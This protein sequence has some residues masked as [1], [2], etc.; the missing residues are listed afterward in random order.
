SRAPRRRRHHRRRLLRLHPGAHPADRPG[1]SRAPRVES[2]PRRHVDWP[3][4]D[5][6]LR[7]RRR[8]ILERFVEFLRVDTVS[9]QPERVPPAAGWL[10]QAMERVGLEARVLETGGNPVVLGERHAPGA[11]R[12]LLL[13]SHFATKPAPPA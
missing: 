12:T 1:R 3:A 13:Y 8:P 5:R 7:A 11:S 9:Q 10:A 6:A 2:G 4:F